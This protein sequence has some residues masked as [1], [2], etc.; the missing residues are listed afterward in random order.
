MELFLSKFPNAHEYTIHSFE[1]NPKMWKKFN[2]KKKAIF[3]GCAIWVHD[4]YVN[5]YLSPSPTSHSS[6]VIK[7]KRTGNLSKKP[8]KVPCIDLSMWIKNNISETDYLVVKLDIEGAEY[9]VL[10]KILND[11]VAEKINELYVD[12][13][14][15]KID[16]SL[17]D[18][19]AIVERLKTAG[20]QPLSWSTES[21]IFGKKS[22]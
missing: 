8:T 7:N 10:D 15:T 13:H 12:W 6:S 17:E 20:I 9:S 19:K 18:H 5:F 2:Q 4:G 21:G 11:G 1:A 22:E 14:Y 16:V 3:H